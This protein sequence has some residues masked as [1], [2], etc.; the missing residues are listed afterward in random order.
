MEKR[1]ERVDS[2]Q[3]EQKKA[4][5]V[6]AEGDAI[7]IMVEFLGLGIQNALCYR[8]EQEGDGGRGVGDWGVS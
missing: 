2:V 8:R 4:E 1:I 5:K 7:A 3:L 6:G